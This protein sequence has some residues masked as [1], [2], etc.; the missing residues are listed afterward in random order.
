M[1]GDLSRHEVDRDSA[2]VSALREDPSLAPTGWPG[3]RWLISMDLVE[4]DA[5]VGKRDDPAELRP[6]FDG[7]VRDLCLKIRPT[8]S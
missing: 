5:V 4:G 8:Q 2:I 7:S 3:A 6:A 1:R